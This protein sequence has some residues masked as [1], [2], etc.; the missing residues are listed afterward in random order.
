MGTV[1]TKDVLDQAEEEQ[2]EFPI[3]I[4]LSN[5][6]SCTKGFCSGFGCGEE[7]MLEKPQDNQSCTY[8]YLPSSFQVT[9]DS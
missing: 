5:N 9:S 8:P 1:H 7:T 6:V 4:E 3:V 2:S